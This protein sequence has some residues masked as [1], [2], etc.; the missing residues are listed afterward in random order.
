MANMNDMKG[1]D[2]GNMA[3]MDGMDHT[4]HMQH[5]AYLKSMDELTQFFKQLQGTSS[6][7]EVKKILGNIKQHIKKSHG[8]F[9]INCD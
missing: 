2:H 9:R 8:S 4:T 3:N 7:N 1:M 6:Q 5:M